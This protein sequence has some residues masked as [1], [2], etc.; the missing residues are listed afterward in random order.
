MTKSLFLKINQSSIKILNID[1]GRKVFQTF[2]NPYYWPDC[3]KQKKKEKKK[4]RKFDDAMTILPSR[5]PIFPSSHSQTFQ[6]FFLHFL[7]SKTHGSHGG[8]DARCVN[9]HPLPTLLPFLLPLLHHF[10]IYS[11][12]PLCVGC[13]RLDFFF[14]R[15]GGVL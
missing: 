11:S 6:P 8:E 3:L 2:N 14:P 13:E 7:Y 5:P 12:S 4:K 10:S 15:L 9:L 1:L